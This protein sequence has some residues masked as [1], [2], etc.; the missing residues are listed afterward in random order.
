MQRRWLPQVWFRNL[1]ALFGVW[2]V[3]AATDLP[4]LDACPMHA[5]PAGEMQHHGAGAPADH[6][7][8]DPHSN[9]GDEAPAAPHTCLCISACNAATPAALDHAAPDPAAPGVA[10]GTSGFSPAGSVSLVLWI[11]YVLPFANAPPVQLQA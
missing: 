3:L 8:H 5:A 2:F 6:L 11:D 4:L 10:E 1:T 7:G 9:G